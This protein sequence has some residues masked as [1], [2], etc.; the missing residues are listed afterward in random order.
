MNNP[1]PAHEFHYRS[2][3][4]AAGHRP[5]AHRSRHGDAG[6]EFRGHRPLIDAPDPRRIDIHASLRDP[7]G[8]ALGQWQVA[9]FSERR[10][11]RVYVLA[12]LSAS[13]G[14]AGDHQR[15]DVL[16]DFTDAAARSAWRHGDAFGFVGAD[17][18]VR[19][20]F[21]LPPSRQRGLGTLLADR[22][23]AHVPAGGAGGLAEARRLLPA[24]RALIFLVSDF[25]WPPELVDRV[26]A[27]L[28]HHELVPVVLSDRQ[29]FEPPARGLVTLRDAESGA[30]RL[31][32]MRPALRE[33]WRAGRAAREQR[34]RELF[35]RH[36]LDPLMLGDGYDAD[37]VSA[38]FVQP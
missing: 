25:H 4:P 11:L 1:P 12:D 2:F 23:R 26:L 7:I 28:A 17:D 8:L 34:L 16:A 14:Y 10:A 15:L 5:G 38:H 33:R 37:A 29:E 31:L 18:R 9:V 30:Q 27:P 3:Q 19:D 22:L 36:R 24:Q 20:D 21:V 35:H 32:W 6:L 13:M